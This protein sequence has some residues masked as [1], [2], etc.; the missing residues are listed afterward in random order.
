LRPIICASLKGS[1]KENVYYHAV[2]AY[3]I[4]SVRMIK[5]RA[6]RLKGFS[7]S[8]K[9]KPADYTHHTK[10]KFHWTVIA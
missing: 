2:T 6:P 4:A 9:S 3:K 5:T 10:N 7:R 1:G 8:L